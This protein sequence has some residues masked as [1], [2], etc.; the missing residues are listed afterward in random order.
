MSTMILSECSGRMQYAV[1]SGSARADEKAGNT[2]KK[3]NTMQIHLR[4]IKPSRFS[5]CGSGKEKTPEGVKTD[6]FRLA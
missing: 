1:F 4:M 5:V 3:D 2:N 6:H